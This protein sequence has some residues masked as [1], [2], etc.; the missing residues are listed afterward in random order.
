MI[1]KNF[2]NQKENR[3]ERERENQSYSILIHIFLTG[4][5]RY[6]VTTITEAKS[7]KRDRI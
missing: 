4:L 7:K 5:I 2:F 6:D 1:R 3:K